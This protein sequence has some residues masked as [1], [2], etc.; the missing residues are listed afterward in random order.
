MDFDLLMQNS[1]KA[2][3]SAQDSSNEASS[4]ILVPASV[5]QIIHA[6]NENAEKPNT[7]DSDVC[8]LDSASSPENGF[9]GGN[10]DVQL[11]HSPPPIGLNQTSATTVLTTAP[12]LA[13]ISLKFE[14]IKP[15]K[16]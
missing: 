6:S 4:G 1:P 16:T 12:S 11:L 10:D 14:D 7:I 15:S 13:D 3:Y 9:A 8:M 5:P 2:A